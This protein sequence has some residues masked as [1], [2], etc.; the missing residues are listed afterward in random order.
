MTRLYGSTDLFPDDR[1]NACRPWQGVNY[2]TSHDGFTLYDLVAYNE[3]RNWANGH[4]NADGANDFSWNCGWEGD[5]G[6]GPKVAQ[7]RK[8]QVKNFC[9][10]LMLS[11]GTPM[12]RMGDEFLQTQG[13]NNNPY[14]QDNATTWLD[15]ERL[16]R[17][18]DVF[19]FFQRMIAFRKSH[20]SI[21]RR[22]FWR[23]DIRWYGV[24]Q[25]VDMSNESQ[26]L[27]Y[28]LHGETKEDRDL[29]VMV[30]SSIRD[31]RFGIH[32]GVAGQW[33]RVIDTSLH[34]PDDIVD[35]G[36]EAAVDSSFYDVQPL[37]V[38]VLRR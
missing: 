37:S 38:V 33:K 10:L 2:I 31:W 23:D 12:F 27:A 26:T 32:E 1:I 14:N 21:A 20:P 9:C 28:C 15:W 11:A 3:K 8:Q 4:N 19:R 36:N 29:Y 13:G 24:E 18:R 25:A 7:L 35:S 5:D 30:N 22:H 16:D 17:H 6:T 34:N